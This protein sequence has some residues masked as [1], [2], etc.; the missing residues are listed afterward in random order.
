MFTH[1]LNFSLSED[2]DENT[3]VLDLAVYRWDCRPNTSFCTPQSVKVLTP[4][5]P[6]TPGHL[7]DRRGHPADVRQN[8][9]QREGASSLPAPT[10]LSSLPGFPGSHNSTDVE[11]K[12]TCPRPAGHFTRSKSRFLES[13]MTNSYRVTVPAST[14]SVFMGACFMAEAS[15]IRRLL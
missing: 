4:P 12:N 7:L 13:D 9:R 1:R 15:L 5:T 6:Q 11:M 8:Q 3:L 14:L 10:W 2:E